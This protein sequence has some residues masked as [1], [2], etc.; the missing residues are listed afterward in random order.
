MN[1]AITPAEYRELVGIKAMARRLNA[2]VNDLSVRAAEIVGTVRDRSHHDYGHG[3]D[4]VLD[5]NMAVAELL[6]KTG[7]VV[8]PPP[9]APF[10]DWRDEVSTIGKLLGKTDAL[11]DLD[12]KAWRDSY[13]KQGLSPAHAWIQE[14]RAEGGA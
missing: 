2:Q 11:D 10:I 13:F 7:I 4:F 3:G 14:L 9:E 5:D 12:W 6:Q 8:L 1:D